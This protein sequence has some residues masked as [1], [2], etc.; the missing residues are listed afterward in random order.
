MNKLLTLATILTLTIGTTFAGTTA[1]LTIRGSVTGVIDIAVT[2]DPVVTN[3][4]LAT[5]QTDLTIASVNEKSNKAA[6]Y[7]VQLDSANAIA[8]AS[9]TATLNG[10]AGLT[11]SLD[12][13]LKYDGASVTFTNGSAVITDTT[14]TTS[15]SGIDKG[16]TI[17]YTGDAGLQEGT[18]EDT[19]TFTIAA[20]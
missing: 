13:T 6:G 15:A 19:L 1:N 14:A 16:L 4:D 12:Y 10:T 20:K 17:S 8:A 5:T 2:P 9:N 11:D 3:L 7:T 18:Y